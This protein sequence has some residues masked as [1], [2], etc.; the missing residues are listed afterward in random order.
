MLWSSFLVGPD[1]W[2]CLFHFVWGDRICSSVEAARA[3]FAPGLLRLAANLLL[4]VWD[5]RPSG[6]LATWGQHIVGA[7]LLLMARRHFRC[8]FVVIVPFRFLL[9]TNSCTA[10][11]LGELSVLVT[12]QLVLA[13]YTVTTDV[14]SS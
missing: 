14:I 8:R 6:L 3:V 1:R 2:G 4:L 13:A 9:Y 12:A 11:E 10:R 5:R 7:V